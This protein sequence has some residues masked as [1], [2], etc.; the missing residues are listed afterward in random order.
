VPDKYEQGS[1]IRHVDKSDPPFLFLHGTAD[2]TVP[3]EQAEKMAMALRDV[4]VEAVID[5]AK[6]A[7]HGYFNRPP[8]YEPTLHS[9]EKFLDKHFRPS[10]K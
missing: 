8:H 9:M 1:P 10:P 5:A 6:G 4:G 3:F 7:K 2:T